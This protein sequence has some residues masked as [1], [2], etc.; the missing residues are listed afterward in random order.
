MAGI[1]TCWMVVAPVIELVTGWFSVPALDAPVSSVPL[2]VTEIVGRQPAT[3]VGTFSSV[4]RRF[5]RSACKVGL[6][7]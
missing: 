2:V 3:A 5:A 7:R 4:A 1:V 6:V